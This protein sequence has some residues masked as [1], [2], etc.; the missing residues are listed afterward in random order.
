M[1]FKSL[2][3]HRKGLGIVFIGVFLLS[4]FSQIPVVSSADNVRIGIDSRSALVIM[5]KKL[6]GKI[7]LKVQAP[8][9]AN[10][11]KVFFNDEEVHST[12]KSDFNWLFS[13]NDY[14][15]GDVEIKVVAQ[16]AEGQSVE[17]I[18]NVEFLTKQEFN[19]I[20]GLIFGLGGG[21]VVLV[22]LIVVFL[23]KRRQ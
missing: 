22:G 4:L 9:D 19:K 20:M 21:I 5:N 8:E 23:R 7:V 13:T 16:T 15:S 14:S 1:R 2:S 6:Y 18:K 11:V 17:G 10:S 3:S 12:E